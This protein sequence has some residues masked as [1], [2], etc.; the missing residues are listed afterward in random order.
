MIIALATPIKVTKEELRTY[1]PNYFVVELPGHDIAVTY[2]A[3][4]EHVPETKILHFY[5]PTD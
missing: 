2:F 4:P 3:S 1:F 5:N